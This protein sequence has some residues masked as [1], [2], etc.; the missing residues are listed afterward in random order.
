VLYKNCRKNN[1]NKEQNMNK[2]TPK[3][4]RPKLLTVIL[5]LIQ[6]RIPNQENHKKKRTII[7]E[8]NK[9]TAFT[10]AEVLI[11]LLVISVIAAMTIPT[12]IAKYRI[13]QSVV[14]LKET[15]AVM[16]NAIKLVGEDYGYPDEWGLTGRNVESTQIIVNILKKYL[17]VSVD[18][19]GAG[20]PLISNVCFLK[21]S[22][23]T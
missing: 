14:K 5:N 15:Y 18:C 3:A 13:Q 17:K 12:I 4:S 8:Y 11:T 22:Y 1:P 7:A 19:G 23:D 10:L 6:N 2:F 9:K 16:S 20:E 21:I